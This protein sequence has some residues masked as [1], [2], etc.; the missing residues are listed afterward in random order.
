[1]PQVDRRKAAASLSKQNDLQVYQNCVLITFSRTACF[2]RL[3]HTHVSFLRYVI[4]ALME[5]VYGLVGRSMHAFLKLKFSSGR[6][7]N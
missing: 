6:Y 1:V 3:S 7:L 2:S 4:T 5:S